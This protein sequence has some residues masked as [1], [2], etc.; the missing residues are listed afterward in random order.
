MEVRLQRQEYV[1]STLH[2]CAHMW[3]KKSNCSKQQLLV[4]MILGTGRPQALRLHMPERGPC[5]EAMRQYAHMRVFFFRF[6][7]GF[8]HRS[9]AQAL[10]QC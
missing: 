8:L 2:Y 5:R 7:R 10:Q 3:N 1:H 9:L 6:R 4:L